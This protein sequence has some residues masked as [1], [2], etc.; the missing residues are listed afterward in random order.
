MHCQ[1]TCLSNLRTM[2]EDTHGDSKCESS[3]WGRLR[4][5]C[6]VEQSR[7]QGMVDDSKDDLNQMV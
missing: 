7:Q 5:T 6:R 3:C 2:P 1:L 4:W